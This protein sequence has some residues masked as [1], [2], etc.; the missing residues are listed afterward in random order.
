MIVVMII[1]LLLEIAVPNYVNT[2]SKSRVQACISDLQ[3]IDGAK[4]QYAMVNGLA[5][6]ATVNDATALVPRYL[7][8]WPSGPSTG[9]YA[10]NPVGTNP[11][12]N[13]KDQPWFT[14]HCVKVLDSSC[15]F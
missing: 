6:G 2:R 13:G 9:T 5:N 14:A 7:K 1:A 8:A 10:A 11:T 15:P 12:F 4:Q 3:E